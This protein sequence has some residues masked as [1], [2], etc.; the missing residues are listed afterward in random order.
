L[1]PLDIL[2][3]LTHQ[4]QQQ[5]EVRMAPATDTK[6]SNKE[7]ATSFLRLVTTGKIREAFDKYVAPGYRHHNP[8]FKGDA[9][10]LKAGMEE[11]DVE[12]PNK[13]FEIQRVLADGDEVA[14]H[15]H[16]KLKPGEFEFAAVHLFRFQ[17]KRIVEMW[18]VL[19]Q[20]PLE[21][22]NENGMF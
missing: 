16:V 4:Q 1:F 6:A 17:D 2:S 13:A 5:L 18:D 10:S 20:V 11:N 8:Y 12:F 9:A 19:Q 15:S 14:V 7:A 21:G 22:T 3:N